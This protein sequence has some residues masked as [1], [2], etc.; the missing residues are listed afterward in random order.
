MQAAIGYQP[1][2]SGGAGSPGISA[3]L[4]VLEVLDREGP[5]HARRTRARDRDREEHAAPGLL[6]H[7]RAR[8]GRPRCAHRPHRARAQGRVARRTRRPLAADRGI[9]RRRPP[10]RGSPQRDH[11]P[12]R[13]RRA[14]Q[15]V[16]RQGGDH[17]PGPPRD[18]GRKPA[19]GV[20]RG[21][22]PGAARGPS[23]GG[24][25]G[26]VRRLRARDADRPAARRTRRAVRILREARRRGYAEN[27]DETA[28]GLHCLAVPVGPPG[29]VAAG[30]HAVRAD[31]PD[32]RRPAS[33]R[34][35]PTCSGPRGEI[36]PQGPIG[37]QQTSAIQGFL[38]KSIK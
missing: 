12:D 36:V 1:G 17:A 23:R 25:R 3:V 34:C 14:R 15:C 13:P 33:A 28:L 2:R 37:E 8:L 26:T 21:V 38:T 19:S 16:H 32:D 35:S 9:P 18:R 20:R 6:D 30:D 4:D 29:R 7:V 11:V 27:V 24:G 10:A 31:R 5:D 22:R